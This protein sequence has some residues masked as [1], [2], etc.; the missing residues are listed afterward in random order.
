MDVKGLK[1]LGLKMFS[2]FSNTELVNM[3]GWVDQ[4]L[5]NKVEKYNIQTGI[6]HYLSL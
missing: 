3:G 5:S 1:R 2:N 4:E 6:Y